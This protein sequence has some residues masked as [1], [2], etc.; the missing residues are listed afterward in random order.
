MTGRG[1]EAGGLRGWSSREMFTL[2]KTRRDRV[3]SVE[4]QRYKH[5]KID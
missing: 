5:T 2:E 1:V 4:E 3:R